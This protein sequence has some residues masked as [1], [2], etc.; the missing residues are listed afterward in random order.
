MT[1]YRAHIIGGIDNRVVNSLILPNDC[2]SV[3]KHSC[4]HTLHAE[5]RR[6]VHSSLT[7]K[8]SSP[9]TK[10]HHSPTS[11]RSAHKPWFAWKKRGKGEGREVEEAEA[12]NGS[13]SSKWKR[14]RG[15]G[16][17]SAFRAWA[18]GF[19]CVSARKPE[20]HLQSSKIDLAGE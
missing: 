1:S 10:T 4:L 14:G 15:K 5:S 7:Q 6:H 9:F 16:I 17:Q 8:N 19:K 18:E 20:A 13:K 12:V 2:L 11:A 3:P